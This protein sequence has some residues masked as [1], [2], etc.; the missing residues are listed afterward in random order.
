MVAVLGIFGAL[1]AGCASAGQTMKGPELLARVRAAYLHVP[2]VEITVGDLIHGESRW[3]FVLRRGFTIAEESSDRYPSRSP[4]APVLIV[5]PRERRAYAFRY[6]A[7]C[8]EPAPQYWGTAGP[9]RSRFPNIADTQVETA[10]R[11]G[12]LWRL[13]VQYGEF[14][15]MLVD[16]KTLLIKSLVSVGGHDVEHYKALMRAPTFPTPRPLCRK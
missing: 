14:D 10:R 6:T 7:K 5:A 11:T 15:T 13:P 16:A 12:S 4:T 9:P 3:T 2:A 1:A 8:W